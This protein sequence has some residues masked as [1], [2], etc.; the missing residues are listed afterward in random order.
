MFMSFVNKHD[1]KAEMKG[2]SEQVLERM[3]SNSNWSMKKKDQ[4]NIVS[5]SHY[6]RFEYSYT[7]S[8]IFYIMH[9]QHAAFQV[10]VE[11]CFLHDVVHIGWY[12]LLPEKGMFHAHNY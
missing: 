12:E 2:T 10:V 8:I 6:Y 4:F 3:G 7:T 1:Y 9:T 11:K 5:H